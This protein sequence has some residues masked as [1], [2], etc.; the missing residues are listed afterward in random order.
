MPT[1]NDDVQ[2]YLRWL[3]QPD[4]EGLES[5]S[6]DTGLSELPTSTADDERLDAAIRA[7]T[8]VVRGDEIDDDERSATEAI[9]IPGKRPVVDVIN[10]TYVT[11]GGEFAYFG[12]EIVRATLEAVIPSVGRVELPDD[13]RMPY[14]GTGFLVGDGLLMTN[15]HVAELFAYGIGREGLAFVSGRS[16][17]VDFLQERDREDSAM[18]AISTIVM[19]HPFWDL[20]L[21]AVTGLDD[22]QPLRLTVEDSAS[23]RGHGVAVIGYPAFDPRNNVDLQN[24]IFNRTFNVKRLQPGRLRERTG[25]RSFGHAV[26]AVAHDSSTLGGNSGSLVLDVTTGLVAGL[27][28]AGR[29]L[30]ANYAVPSHELAGDGR[31]VDAGVNFSA[32]TTPR[33]T[34]WD[35]YWRRADPQPIETSITRSRPA[36]VAASPTPVTAVAQTGEAMT[37]VV[38]LEITVRVGAAYPPATAPV[39]DAAVE[40]LVEPFHDENLAGRSGYDEQ[41]LGLPV[42]LPEVLDPS[43]TAKA[44]D[45]DPVLRYEHFSI[46]VHKQRRL[47]L[48]SCSNV[49]GSPAA[50]EPEPGRDYSRRGLSGL[51]DNDREKWFTDPR[52]PAVHQLPDRFYNK[53]RQAFD[54]GHVIRREDAAWGATFDEVR[55][56]NG[57]TYH[58]TNCTPQVGDFNRKIWL[59]LENLVLGAAATERLCVFAGPVLSDDDPEFHGVADDGSVVVRIPQ[60]YWKI[61][62]ARNDHGLE[63]FAFVLDQDLT[64][65]K[66]EASLDSSEFPVP[67]E[68]RA[69]MISVAA[70]E[71]MLGEI[72]FADAIRDADQ[73]GN[74]HGDEVVAMAGI[75]HYPG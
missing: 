60:Q 46:V 24:E 28:F 2:R 16:A 58:V 21:L 74:L 75:E 33:S 73:F 3:T 32:T 14:G 53:D 23:L 37:W 52:I 22:R 39:V 62:V 26:S 12:D 4:D 47:P 57:D 69:R 20:A 56:G 49:D 19:I 6:H 1:T 38:P 48:F 11:P 25:V 34:A 68:W 63:S 64:G 54:K 51:G 40:K 61:A 5:L 36:H 31:V 8:K 65:V 41:F 55:R 45:G 10:G 15:R 17:G 13:P 30:E 70:L 29:Y 50:K 59:R 44:D 18:F 7:V 27:H 43:I 35:D 67:P 9:I 72:R 66:L 42:P 71:Q